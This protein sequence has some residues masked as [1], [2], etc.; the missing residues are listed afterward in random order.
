M[1]NRL[2][3]NVHYT[4]TA[5]SYGKPPTSRPSADLSSRSGYP[6][7]SASTAVTLTLPQGY[8]KLPMASD[9]YGLPTPA[10]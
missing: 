6:P 5:I 3:R 8:G 2:S 1:S 7:D 9:I 4:C 10:T